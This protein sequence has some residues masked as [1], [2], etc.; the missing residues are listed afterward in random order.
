MIDFTPFNKLTSALVGEG[1]LDISKPD[2][3]SSDRIDEEDM[4]LL[5]CC[6]TE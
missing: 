5:A 4:R 2:V 3:E 1:M 6:A